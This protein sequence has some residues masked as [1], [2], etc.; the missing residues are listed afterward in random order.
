MTTPH[1]AGH[2]LNLSDSAS[3]KPYKVHFRITP[4]A[5]GW[6]G[7][8][9]RGRIYLWLSSFL[10]QRLSPKDIKSPTLEFNSSVLLGCTS[11]GLDIEWTS[12]Q[13]PQGSLGA[14]SRGL[15]E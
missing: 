4:R 13:W 8:K 12:E 14:G 3:Q 7:G 10:D 11:V 5:W 6:E 1:Q 9:G 15:A 2:L